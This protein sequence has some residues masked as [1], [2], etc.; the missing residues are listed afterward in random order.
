M[1]LFPIIIGNLSYSQVDTQNLACCRETELTYMNGEIRLAGVLLSP[2]EAGEYPAAV[3]LQ[4]SGNSDRSNAW[5]RAVAEIFVSNGVA[6]LLT[7]KRGSGQSR[8]RWL[9]RDC[10]VA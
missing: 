2:I 1:A 3:I 5:T 7:D 8:Q 10:C 9:S 4:G 6:V